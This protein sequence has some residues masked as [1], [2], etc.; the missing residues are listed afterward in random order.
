MKIIS[1]LTSL[2]ITLLVQM[3]LYSQNSS[4]LIDQIKDGDTLAISIEMCEG[5]RGNFSEQILIYKQDSIYK[6]NVKS[7]LVNNINDVDTI[8]ILNNSHLDSIRQYQSNVILGNF[9][10]NSWYL[11]RQAFIHKM[12]CSDLVITRQTYSGQEYSLLKSLI[13]IQE[14]NSENIE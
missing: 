10:K 14:M 7:N 13:T 2:I 5:C 4:Y 8:F 6:T 1:K 9:K 12:K 11:H 3:Q